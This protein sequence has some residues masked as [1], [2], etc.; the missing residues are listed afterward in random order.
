[1]GHA[2]LTWAFAEVAPLFLRGHEPGQTSLATLENKHDT[3]KA[4]SRLAHQ[5]ARAV[6]GMLKRKPAFALAQCLRPSGSS[7]GAPGAE[8]DTAG[9]SLHRTAMQP[10]R[11][12]SVTAEVRLGPLALRPAL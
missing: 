5:L 7:A 2:P 3:G 11:A 1:M 9:R 6:Y 12:A 10:M 8:R 4:L